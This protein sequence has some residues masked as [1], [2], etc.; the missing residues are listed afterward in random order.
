MWKKR[1]LQNDL[2]NFILTPEIPLSQGNS[3]YFA[4]DVGLRIQPKRKSMGNVFSNQDV[5]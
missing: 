1:S 4:F 3:L 5:N 2:F